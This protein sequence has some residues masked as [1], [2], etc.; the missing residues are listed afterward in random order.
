VAYLT[1]ELRSSIPDDLKPGVG[2]HLFGCD[3]C[4]TVC[5]FNASTLSDLPQKTT[6]SDV[7][8][9]FA[10]DPRWR[11]I[12][13]GEMVTLDESRFGAL[14]RG[15]PVGRATRAGLARNAAVVLGNRRD[16]SALDALVVAQKE[17]PNIVADAAAWAERRITE[18]VV[19]GR[20]PGPGDPSA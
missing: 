5:P 18:A 2:E 1:I 13:L 6:R 14:R 12:S 19:A 15:S 11:E 3:D 8:D 20:D 16:V 17:G 10:T 4:Q 9:R 7:D